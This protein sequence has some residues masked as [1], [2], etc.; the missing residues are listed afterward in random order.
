V[1]ALVLPPLLVG[2]LAVVA[3]LQPL[4][5]ADML[6]QIRTGEAV[7]R[8]HG[9]QTADL[10]SFPFRGHA[11]HD[12][13]AAFEAV[14]AFIHGRGGMTALW[15]TA[16]VTL[17]A[18]TMLAGHVARRLTP[19]APARIV[20]GAVLLS[21]LAYRSEPRAELATFLAIALAHWFRRE[22][23]GEPDGGRG[24]LARR[25]APMLI[26]AL[27]APFHGLVWWT[28]VVPAAHALEGMFERGS[29]RRIAI[30]LGVALGC[31]LAPELTAPGILVLNF[32]ALRG[33]A[34]LQHIN[35]L[36]SPFELLYH[37]VAVLPAYSWLIGALGWWGLVRARRRDPDGPILTSDALLLGLLLVPGLRWARFALL[38]VMAAMP[39]T[40]A[41]LAEL[42][43]P[44][45]RHRVLSVG[46]PA[47]AWLASAVV[48][49]ESYGLLNKTVG[50]DFD[51]QP[52][53]AV[54][55]LRKNQ[56]DARLF[57]SYNYGSYL[58]YAQFPPRGVVIDPRA[59]TLY[60]DQYVKRYYDAVTDPKVFEAWAVE[61]PF[62]T[63]LLAQRHKG[64]KPLRDYLD[65]AP[66]W[67]LAF[68]DSVSLVYTRR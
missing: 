24:D 52:V 51:G 54:E 62:D 21:A 41:G 57:H 34:I 4:G 18:T 36:R 22:A 63:V 45:L 16:L 42:A 17:V 26:A 13:E 1:A 31:V 30:D 58:I 53:G 14:V 48:M 10:F 64:T 68:S 49:T 56:P 9:R 43:A 32:R 6:W 8:N 25:L 40:L 19:S 2:G 12:H 39:W 38:P 5:A 61:L 55:Y 37:R 23:R 67:R 27:L 66:A 65:K 60:P 50:F 47:I 59:Q 20:G 11:I 29:R 33:S 3:R 46:L 35:E 15:W 44:P 28:A 7:L